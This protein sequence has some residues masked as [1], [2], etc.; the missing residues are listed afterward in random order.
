MVNT[1]NPHYITQNATGTSLTQPVDTVDFP[2]SGLIKA[3]NQMAAGNVVVKTGT[4]FDINQTGGN[5][6]VAAGKILRNGKYHEVATK[7]FADSSL[8]TTYAKGYHLLVV[9]DGREGGETVDVLYMRPPTANERVPEFKLGDTIVAMVE[10]SSAT[11]AGSRL[12]QYFTTNKESNSL[13][14]AYANSNVYTQ[15]MTVDADADGDVT[16]ENVV[17]DKDIIFKVNDGG[18][19]TEV[20]RIDGSTS[21]V[22]I[23]ENSPDSMLHLKSASAASPTIKIEN[24]GTESS[25][26]EIIFQRTGAAAAS[27]D[28]GH[29]KFKALDDGG[30]THTYAGI[31]AD[32][33]DETAGTEDG[34]ILFSVAKGGTDN[35]EILRLSGSE[36]LVFNDSSN[37]MDFR[38]E[39]NGN[40][41]ML[42][43]DAGKD[44][45]GIGCDPSTNVALD[46]EGAIGLDEI[47]TPTATADR[48]AIYTKTDNNLYFQ[49][50]AGTE[51][52]LLKGGLHSIYIPA[53]A[54]YPNTTNGCSALTQVELSNGPE[55]KVLDFD[56]ASDE[57]CQFTISFPK[58]WDEGTL[59][60]EVYWMGGNTNTSDVVWQLKG[61]CFDDSDPVDTTF[62]SP[63]NTTAKAHSGTANDINRSVSASACTVKNATTDSIVFF[64]LNRDVSADGYNA[65]A[66]LLGMKIFYTI[67]SGNDA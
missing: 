63:A 24:T 60:Y 8:T 27:Q 31:F 14:I 40:A 36:G 53:S 57:F 6:V 26:A 61:V 25:E 45:V 18:T 51:T 44:A 2:H 23:G 59:T 29:I 28:I 1:T 9:A 34:R 35:V 4:D 11:S 20:M 15:A 43:V 32:A 39:S 47:S 3:L 66:R 38:V 54:M 37:D 67:D 7:T 33:Q 62:G 12:I 49:D 52:V 56:T 22:G 5:L 16:F 13:S 19:P 50:G 65:D 48:G 64:Q 42:R 21:R 10:Y 58:S 46:V 55:I 30:A 41:N 17:Q